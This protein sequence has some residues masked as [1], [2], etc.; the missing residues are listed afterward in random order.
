MDAHRDCCDGEGRRVLMRVVDRLRA[1][2]VHSVWG[3]V[4]AGEY[5]HMYIHMYIHPSQ[6]CVKRGLGGSVMSFHAR[7]SCMWGVNWGRATQV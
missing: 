3:W 7:A 5:T 1:V 2:V 6:D 4:G